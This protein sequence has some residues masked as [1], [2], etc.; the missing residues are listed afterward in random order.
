MNQQRRT[1]LANPSPLCNFRVSFSVVN[2]L[3]SFEYTLTDIS[4]RG[5][6][7]LLRLILS[8][9]DQRFSRAYTVHGWANMQS[10]ASRGKIPGAP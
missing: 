10:L 3:S 8:P 6:I 4:L 1:S 2:Y 7:I 9:F 5:F